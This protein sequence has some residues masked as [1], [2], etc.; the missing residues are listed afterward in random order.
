MVEYNRWCSMF[1]PV[2]WTLTW[3]FLRGA[4]TDPLK[5]RSPQSPARRSI[6]YE[7]CLWER[8]RFAYR[9]VRTLSSAG[10]ESRENATH[11][12]CGRLERPRIINHE[13]GGLDLFCVRHLGG[14]E[15][16]RALCLGR[17]SI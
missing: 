12:L 11:L 13:I 2:L 14:H 6:P 10:A 5:N 7:K 8:E 17:A 9:T 1:T 4:T 3:E 16:G 15:I